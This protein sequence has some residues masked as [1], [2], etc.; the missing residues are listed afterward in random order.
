VQN[1][2]IGLYGKLQVRNRA[3][4]AAEAIERGLL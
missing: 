1:I 3:Q 4:A 2:Q